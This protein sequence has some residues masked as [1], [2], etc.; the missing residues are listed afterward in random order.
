VNIKKKLA[1]CGALALP[2]AG[3]A[4]FGG[5]QAASAAAPLLTCQAIAPASG[6]GGGETFT[7]NSDG[8]DP[9]SA[10]VD[11]DSSAGGAMELA[12]GASNGATTLSLTDPAGSTA[13]ATTDQVLTITGASG[14]YTVTADTFSAAPPHLPDSVTITPGL[15]L[16][17]GVLKN[18]VETY[19]P[20]A[21]K[22]A[23]TVAPTTNTPFRTVKDAV[24]TSGSATI[25]SA[26][27]DFVNSAY[28]GAPGG[29][30]VGAPV[31]GE[32]GATHGS[33]GTSITSSNGA[34]LTIAS[35]TNSTTAVLS[36]VVSQETSA[37]PPPT[38][39]NISGTATVTIGETLDA[40][41][42]VYVVTTLSAS[43]CGS[44]ANVPG[45]FAPLT[46]S[47]SGVG[48]AAEQNSAL[49]LEAAPAA[50]TFNITYPTIGSGWADSG[51]YP[52][53]AS[54]P[55]TTLAFPGG[56]DN[57][58]SLEGGQGACGSGQVNCDSYTKGAATGDWPT[59]KGSLGLA[60]YG[61]IFCTLGETQAIN[62]N[63]GPDTTANGGW[64]SPTNKNPLT[65][66]DGASGNPSDSSEASAL[67]VIITLELNPSANAYGSDNTS[68]TSIWNAVSAQASNAVF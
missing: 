10:S 34:T 5:A 27:A 35:V 14:T 37:G 46:A 58:F 30:D 19:K 48:G 2:F 55:S 7:P 4:A 21:S 57:L 54:Q 13:L 11:F 31:N 25:T 42:S 68:P 24:V 28:T 36:S 8:S 61:L 47:L 20:L 38:Y 65:V 52:N 17:D 26:T 16:T 60:A 23:V 1:V 62:S 59:T 64:I 18:G 67:S 63:T 33:G 29:G 53:A 12:V 56:K 49:A 41:G 40:P 44:S 3:L 9:G 39:G 50:T 45:D 51:G 66:C 22:D 6:L 43:E 32:I 15:A